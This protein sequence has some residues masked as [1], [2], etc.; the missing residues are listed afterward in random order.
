[1]I[2]PYESSAIF[3]QATDGPL[4]VS[5]ARQNPRCGERGYGLEKIETRIYE[6]IAIRNAKSWGNEWNIKDRH[7]GK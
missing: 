7:C 6:H 2:A 5:P 1:M 3:A 4:S